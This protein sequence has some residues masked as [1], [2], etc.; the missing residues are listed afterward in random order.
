MAI[1]SFICGYVWIYFIAIVAASCTQTKLAR[2]ERRVG[3][4]RRKN[5]RQARTAAGGTCWEH[6]KFGVLLDY[7]F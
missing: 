2:G 7:W 5:R 3:A 4:S 1:R 6:R